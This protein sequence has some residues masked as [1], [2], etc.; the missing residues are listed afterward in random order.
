MPVPSGSQASS[1]T[2]SRL[3]TLPFPSPDCIGMASLM[4]LADG[5]SHSGTGGR[6]DG[7][8]CRRTAESSPPEYRVMSNRESVRRRSPDPDPDPGP[9]I[10]HTVIQPQPVTQLPS[11]AQPSPRE[12]PNPN[13][14]PNPNIDEPTPRDGIKATMIKRVPE[15]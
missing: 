13:P 3:V 1:W 8:V 2:E 9:S 11:P 5:I 10:P 6:T 15:A 12:R 4:P 7:H 14:N